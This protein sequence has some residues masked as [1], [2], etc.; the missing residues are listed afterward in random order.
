MLEL[1]INNYIG[2]LFLTSAY[3]I[4][5]KWYCTLQGQ[6][7]KIRNSVHIYKIFINKNREIE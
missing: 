6:E 3:R 5:A 2:V 7:T 1:I 4:Y